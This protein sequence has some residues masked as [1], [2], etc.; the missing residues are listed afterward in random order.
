MKLLT[1]Q[2]IVV[3]IARD[4]G[5]V[6]STLEWTRRLDG[7]QTVRFQRESCELVVT[8]D[9]RRTTLASLRRHLM[10]GG[11]SC[12]TSLLQ[13]CHLWAVDHAEALR[14][15]EAGGLVLQ[16]ANDLPLIRAQSPA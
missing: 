1:T 7:V 16:A 11:V 13:R 12:D 15:A 10:R 3:S 9:L 2:R 8:Y 6:R 5:T 4:A 14:R